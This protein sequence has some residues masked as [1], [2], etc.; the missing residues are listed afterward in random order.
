M[1]VIY[2][3]WGLEM[4]FQPLFKISSWLTNI[5]I[6]TINPV[7][8]IPVYDP[9]FLFIGSLSFGD[10]RWSLMVWPPFKCT[11]IPYCLQMFFIA[12][13]ESLVVC[14]HNV[15][16]W[17]T[18]FAGPRLVIVASFL[19]LMS[20]QAFQFYSVNGPVRIFT[21]LQGLMQVFFFLLQF[22]RCW[23]DCSC[24]VEQGAHHTIFVG[25]G[26]VAIPVEI[27]V[28]MSFFSVDRGVKSTIF[29]L[30]WW[31]YPRRLWIHLHLALHRWSECYHV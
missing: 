24:P 9:T 20:G 28:C 5:F 8:L 17:T 7:T 15:R 6:M 4:F 14:D 26:M 11:S 27:L 29:H 3:R 22:T 2:G 25:Y 1:M 21:L 19:L 31:A 10:M 18:D 12:L 13:T 23:T 16:L 30:E